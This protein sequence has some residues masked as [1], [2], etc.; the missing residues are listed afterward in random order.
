[1]AGWRKPERTGRGL[2]VE[3][4]S[5][6]SPRTARWRR[7]AAL[8]ALVCLAIVA[9]PVDPTG[10][11][12]ANGLA[13][14][15][16]GVFP[17]LPALTIDR[18]FGPIAASFAAELG[19]P[20]HLK[21][22]S[23]F[24]KFADQLDQQTYD[25]IFVHPFLYVQAADRSNYLPLARLEGQLSA[26][27]LVRSER[28]WRTWSDLAGRV[29]GLPP[30][31]AAVSELAKIALVDAG[32]MPGTET[33]LRHYRTKAACVQAVSIGTADV[34]V[35]PRF[36][37][38]QIKA[39]GDGKLRVMAATPPINHLVFATHARMPDFDR[40][41]LL[42]LILSWPD[43]EQGRAILATGSWPRFIAARD[44]DYA[45]VRDYDTRLRTLA[46]R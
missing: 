44:E 34:C 1:V 5:A 41:E 27:A 12:Q 8:V 22:S 16:F 32:L 14:F 3:A 38:P 10:A 35:L 21:T 33:T 46:Q 17:Y 24:E 43:T 11:G 2:L 19:R 23:T 7:T 36:V 15:R 13:G 45:Q 18:I 40:K 6:G 28:P 25:I 30:A 31:L 39:L 26:A 20:V 37:L 42:A 29:V 9:A 4:L